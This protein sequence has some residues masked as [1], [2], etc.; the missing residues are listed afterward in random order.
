MDCKPLI[1]LVVVRVWS[2]ASNTERSEFINISYCFIDRFPYFHIFSWGQ[3]YKICWEDEDTWSRIPGLALERKVLWLVGKRV[4]F[5]SWISVFFMP[6]CEKKT[7]HLIL[8]DAAPCYNQQD[9]N[10]Q[11]VRRPGARQGANVPPQR[12]V[13]TSKSLNMEQCQVDLR[14]FCGWFTQCSYFWSVL[15]DPFVFVFEVLMPDCWSED[16]EPLLTVYLCVYLI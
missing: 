1:S 10:R 6:H 4:N 7:H 14:L 11:L 2:G 15:I 5:N 8:R 16:G 3:S 12:F 9:R 13:F